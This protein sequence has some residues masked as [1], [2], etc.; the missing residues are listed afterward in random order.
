MTYSWATTQHSGT[1]YNAFISRN[2]T[3]ADLIVMSG[4]FANL[5]SD[6]GRERSMASRVVLV[7]RDE[8]CPAM[9]GLTGLT[10]DQDL[11]K[12]IRAQVRQ[13]KSDFRDGAIFPESNTH[14]NCTC[15]SAGISHCHLAEKIKANSYGWQDQLAQTL[16]H[17]VTSHLSASILENIHEVLIGSGP[18]DWRNFAPCEVRQARND[19]SY[20]LEAASRAIQ[21]RFMLQKTELQKRAVMGAFLNAIKQHWLGCEECRPGHKGGFPEHKFLRHELFLEVLN[22]YNETPNQKTL[23]ESMSALHWSLAALP[24][25]LTFEK[26]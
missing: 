26:P 10:H 21:A 18:L 2:C 9:M 17:Y 8:F 22:A 14:Q 24:C 7:D 25:P 3:I 4:M 11:G 6:F 16:L 19:P 5:F 13:L 23:E 20:V 12:Y 1:L 15:S